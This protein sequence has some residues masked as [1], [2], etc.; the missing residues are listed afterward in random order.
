MYR[1]TGRLIDWLNFAR[2]ANRTNPPRLVVG[3]ARSQGG[4]NKKYIIRALLV[5][6]TVYPT[7][8]L[9]VQEKKKQ[10]LRNNA[11]LWFQVFFPLNTFCASG[12]KQLGGRATQWKIAAGRSHMW[13][14]AKSINQPTKQPHATKNPTNQ[15]LHQ[16]AAYQSISQ[17]ANQNLQKKALAASKHPLI[18]QQYT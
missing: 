11:I 2:V 3:R 15:S 13:K 1:L 7:F 4:K 17:S 10:Q 16:P 6:Y 8:L 14:S 9:M 18:Q 5:R 12:H